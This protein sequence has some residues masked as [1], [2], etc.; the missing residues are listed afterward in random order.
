MSDSAI[1]VRIEAVEEGA[2]FVIAERDLH[3]AETISKL[4]VGHCTVTVDVE[5]AEEGS[6]VVIDRRILVCAI[7]DLC[8]YVIEIDISTEPREPIVELHK[9]DLAIAINVKGLHQLHLLAYANVDSELLQAITKLIEREGATSV[10]IEFVK[11][12][13]A[14][15]LK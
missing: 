1:M 5:T 2:R 3:A 10:G 11:H 7:G 12:E 8:H 9:S 4:L 13:T 14:E 6:H 15:V